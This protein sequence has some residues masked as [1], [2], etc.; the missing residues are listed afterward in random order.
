MFKKILLAIIV[1]L[2][3]SMVAQKFGTVKVEE[4]I[5]AMPEFT[6]MQTQITETSKKYEEELGKLYEEANRLYTEFQAMQNDA[7]TPESIK[8]RRMQELQERSQKIEQFNQQAANDIQAQREQLMAPIQ[9]KFADAVKSVGAE[10]AFTFI[11]PYEP[12]LLLY[13]STEVVDVTPQVR[14]KLGL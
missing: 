14:A 6:A 1:A 13:Q 5:Q 3:I 7:S 2:P 4:V 10:G 9:Q 12:N 11:F 8:E